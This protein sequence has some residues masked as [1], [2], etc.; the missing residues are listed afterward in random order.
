MKTNRTQEESNR[1]ADE[2]MDCCPDES[3]NDHNAIA[4]AIR[5]GKTRESILNMKETNAYPDT[6]SWLETELPEDAEDEA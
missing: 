3:F 4:E 2:L 1:I 5:K 6:Y